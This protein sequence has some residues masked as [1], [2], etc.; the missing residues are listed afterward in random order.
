MSEYVILTDSSCD[1]PADMAE[2]LGLVVVPLIVRMENKEYYNYLDERDLKLSEFYKK[3]R[4]GIEDVSTSAINIDAYNNAMEPILQSGKD[5][6]CV[7]FSSGLS[8]TY[9]ASRLAAQEM[10]EKYP[11][12]KI[13]AV[14]SLSASLGLGLLLDLTVKEIK[15]KNLT[16]EQ[17]ASFIDDMKLKIA[18][19]V[20]VDD[21][22]YLKK[23]GRIS[24]TTELVGSL[25]NIKPIVHM[26]EEGKL[27]N[28]DK[29]R[30][31]KGAMNNLLKRA[32]SD[33]IDLEN[34]TVFICH[35]D[36]MDTATKMADILKEKASVKECMINSIGPVIGAHT[37][38]GL[39]SIFFVS[40]KR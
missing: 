31:I 11:D 32:Q 23:G 19:L 35:A 4:E 9:N 16:I 40:N 27:V 8:N 1:L 37:G 24:G 7:S 6:L 2:K 18:H 25:L 38:P 13:I 12:R 15:Q 14:D 10:G 33:G 39:I 29:A 34:Q 21:L 3:L 28:I 5:V 26:D 17:A 30:G 36:A 20:I 22:H